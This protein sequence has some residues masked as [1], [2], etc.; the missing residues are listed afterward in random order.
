MGDEHTRRE[1]TAAGADRPK[2]G[3][4]WL[5]IALIICAV[6]GIVLSVE[7]THVHYKAN[8]YADY[9]AF[10]NM[11]E[12]AN[13][14][15]VATSPYSE[16]FG[17]PVAVW[18]FLAYLVLLGLA[19][20]GTRPH[21]DAQL[22]GLPFL[23]FLWSVGALATTA[24][25][26]AIS[27]WLIG[28][29]CILCGGLYVV[30]VAV[31]VLSLI[32]VARWG[33]LRPAVAR[34]LSL[35]GGRPVFA[36]GVL[37]SLLA[38]AGLLIAFYPP[39]DAPEEPSVEPT[40]QECASSAM[41]SDGHPFFGGPSA[42]VT[43]EE[44]SDYQCGHCR[45]AHYLLRELIDTDAYREQVR[46]VHR[47]FPLDQAC[48]PRLRRPFHTRACDA[49]RAA[50]CAGHQGRFWEYND[51]LFAH[52]Q[53]RG[54]LPASAIAGFAAEIGL[55]AEQFRACLVD[56]RTESELR[57]D[58]RDGLGWVKRG[59]PFF[60]I[61]G[62]TFVEGVRQPEDFRRLFDDALARCEAPASADPPPST[63]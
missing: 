42:R 26:A 58:L 24:A 63:P 6:A 48:H 3:G 28:T 54:R 32:H 8:T 9:D 10:C 60:V 44:Y 53:A 12:S 29:F 25:L 57:G 51:K 2:A 7:L 43:I 52:F 21:A 59:T 17:V 35:V 31:F 49:S 19:L 33:G 11:G 41:T 47:H 61:N 1:R 36:G 27:A 46:L 22:R 34:D 13:C 30:N 56:P 20:S 23:L 55:D 15:D 18:G 39:L 50:I 37:V 40:P 14:G 5:T 38:V 45:K 62:E 4:Q 16:V